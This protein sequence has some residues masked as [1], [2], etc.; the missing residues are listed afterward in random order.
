[1]GVRGGGANSGSTAGIMLTTLVALGLAG[2]MIFYLRG[3]N[4]NDD[5]KDLRS[6]QMPPPEGAVEV[7]DGYEANDEA[8]TADDKAADDEA[9]DND[10][11]EVDA[12]VAAEA[13]FRRFGYPDRDW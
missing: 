8:E 5:R 2:G 13:L 12:K 1:M 4:E 9:A 7:E 3:S 10:D 11:D 6:P